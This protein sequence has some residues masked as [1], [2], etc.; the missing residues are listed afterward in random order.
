[1]RPCPPRRPIL[2]A[3]AIAI[4]ALSTALGAMACAPGGPGGMGAPEASGRNGGAVGDPLRALT[5]TLTPRAAVSATAVATGTLPPPSLETV[6]AARTPPITSTRAVSATATR[7][8]SGTATVTATPPLTSATMTPHAGPTASI[9]LPYAAKGAVPAAGRP[10]IVWGAQFTFE[11]DAAASARDIDLELPRLKDA[12]ARSIRTHLRWKDVEPERREPAA[13][14]WTTPDRLIGAY[15]RAGFDVVVSIVDYPAW[16]MVYRCGYGYR[17]PEMA[18]RWA[19]FVRAAA[20]RYDAAPYRVA[21]W[22]IG[23]EVDGK[24]VVTDVDDKR[25]PEWGKGE[26][27]PPQIGCWGDRPAAYLAFLKPAYAAVKAVDPEVPVTFGNLAYATTDI[28]HRDFL[29]RFLDLDSGAYF[30]YVGYHW[31]PELREF[32]PAEPTGPEKYRMI[33]DRLARRGLSKPIWITETYRRTAQGDAQSERDQIRFLTEELPEVLACCPVARVYWFAWTDFPAQEAGK[34]QRG[35]VRSDHTPKLAWPILRYTIQHTDGAGRDI[36]SDGTIAYEFRPA[37]SGVR[38]IIARRP[39][40]T[41][42][43]LRVP[44]QP[45]ETAT[46]T[47]FPDDA[48]RQGTCCPQVRLAARGGAWEVPVS[49]RANYVRIVQRP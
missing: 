14:D 34:P 3:C 43:V 1:M 17:S 44:T 15:S 21:A 5:G 28:F 18:A 22:E 10:S 49:G 39:D 12:G 11:D 2:R 31:F 6:D 13:F 37:R 29:D 19:G 33:A 9:Q 26:P 20:E 32:F 30:D 16:A 40:G 8:L 27:M 38:A 24:T 42:G 23:N 7:A 4:V 45:G 35:L 48:L 36:S 47:T 25:P 46:L 41:N